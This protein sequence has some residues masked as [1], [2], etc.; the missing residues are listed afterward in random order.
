[1]AIRVTT[2]DI[3]YCLFET[4]SNDPFEDCGIIAAFASADAGERRSNPETW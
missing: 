4:L 1:M 2:T 3:E